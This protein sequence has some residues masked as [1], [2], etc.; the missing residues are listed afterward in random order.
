MSPLESGG[1]GRA[2]ESGTC[3]DGEASLADEQLRADGSAGMQA[4]QPLGQSQQ[5]AGGVQPVQEAIQQ[6][7]HGRGRAAVPDHDGGLQKGLGEK[8]QK[9][10]KNQTKKST[11]SLRSTGK[12]SASPTLFLTLFSCL[13]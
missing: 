10:K 1:A 13:G 11:G 8:N 12:C 5:P 6:E 4:V 3:V 2:E 9:T 7:H